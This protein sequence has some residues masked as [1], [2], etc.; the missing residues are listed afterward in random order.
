[1]LGIFIQKFFQ[2]SQINNLKNQA[3]LICQVAAYQTY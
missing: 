3:I 2:Y 1:M